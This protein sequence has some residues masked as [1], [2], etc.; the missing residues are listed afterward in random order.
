MAVST[1]VSLGCSDEGGSDLLM[2]S[3]NGSEAGG[4]SEMAG[5]AASPGSDYGVMIAIVRCRRAPCWPKVVV[6][7]APLNGEFDFTPARGW[8]S[9]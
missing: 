4:G 6:M 2:V 5:E 1:P 3:G 7:G 9:S 8:K